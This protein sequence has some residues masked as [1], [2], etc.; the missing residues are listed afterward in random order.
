MSIGLKL[1]TLAAGEDGGRA[2][3]S[4]CRFADCNENIYYYYFCFLGPDLQQ[5]EVPRLGVKSEL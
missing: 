4:M 1:L 3:L 5:M 2:F